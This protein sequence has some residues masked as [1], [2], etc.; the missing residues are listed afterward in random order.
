MFERYTEKARRTIF[1]ARYEAS[2]FGSPY[3]E[4]E[5]LLLGILREDK[6]LANQFLGSHAKLETLRRSI[7]Q[8]AKTGPKIATSVDL[9]LSRESKRVL[10]YSAEEAERMNHKHIGTPHLL[11]ALFREEKS[12]AAE[13]L[14][15]QGLSLKAVREQVDRSEPSPVLRA[16]EAIERLRQWLAEREAR[17]GL[18]TVESAGTARPGFSIYAGDRPKESEPDQEAPPAEKLEQIQNRLFFI[19]ERMEHAI[20]QHQ[21]E[22]A[23]LCSEEEKKERENLCRLREEFNLEEPPPLVPILC[24]EVLRDEPLSKFRKRCEHY[25]AG[26]VA[27][28]WLL[29]PDSKRAYT[30]TKTAGL[31]EFKGETLRIVDPPLEMDLRTIFD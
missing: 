28:I 25:L 10:A 4:T 18:W 27:A 1:F 17:G 7:E 29:D 11:L 8:R 3:I 16:S 15:E 13:L 22:E 5:H 6:E 9:P 26:G 31:R 20:A 14:H 30:V 21:F 23:R 24:I 19:R 2:Q 12:F